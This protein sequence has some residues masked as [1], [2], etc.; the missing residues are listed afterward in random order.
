MPIVIEPG[1]RIA[2]LF[3]H[4]VV[5]NDD[6]DDSAFSCRRK[7][8]LGGVSRDDFCEKLT[9]EF[10]D[11]SVGSQVGAFLSDVS[12]LMASSGMGVTEQEADLIAGY[13]L[14]VPSEGQDGLL[15]GN[16]SSG[17]ILRV[18]KTGLLLSIPALYAAIHTLV[19]GLTPLAPLAV[20]LGLLSATKGVRDLVGPLNDEQ[21]AIVWALY[22][23]SKE[24]SPQR[25]LIDI[26]NS[27]RSERGLGVLSPARLNTVIEELKKAGVVAQA[28]DAAP[29]L[30]EWIM[31]RP[32]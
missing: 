32:I 23:S 4:D 5:G 29:I 13:L 31:V 11:R 17:K 3:L 6:I 14:S 10:S 7:P 16:F 24:P 1:M 15:V 30:K 18:S 25:T 21:G 2:Q 8:M 12:R 9:T 26:V 19:A 28:G 22:L 20:A 27:E